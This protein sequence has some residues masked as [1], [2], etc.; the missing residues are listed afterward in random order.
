MADL[1]AFVS[2]SGGKD[3]CFAAMKALEA[4]HELTVLLNMMHE[5]GQ[6]SRSHAIPKSVLEAQ[7]KSI[8][9]PIVTCSSTWG[10]YEE[11]YINALKKIWEEYKPPYGI[12]GD[13]DIV[14]HRKWEEKVCEAAQMTAVLPLW[15]MDRR[16]LV[17][18]MI[19]A[20]IKAVIV[21]CNNKLGA[22]FLGR[23]ISLG[24]V[25]DLKRAGVDECGENGEFHTLVLDCPVFST[26][27]AIRELG[28][29]EHGDYHFL[30]FEL[31][32]KNMP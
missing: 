8:G 6:V 26:E 11:N 9:M 20:G 4:G 13:I 1:T 3:S 5:E 12:F 18:E 16:K 21:S 30:D 14:A 22:D 29:H 32:E 2:W 24:L 31:D 7:A 28:C 17:L 23:E 10:A 19:E 27:I 15:Q 25:D